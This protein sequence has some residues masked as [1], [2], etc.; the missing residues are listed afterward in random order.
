MQ[1]GGRWRGSGDDIALRDLGIGWLIPLW[2]AAAYLA[3]SAVSPL[4]T[5]GDLGIDAHAYWLT[6][7]HDDL[8]GPGPGNRDAYLYSPAF[9]TA[10][11]PLTQL[12]WPVFLGIWLACQAATFA[13]LLAPL[14]W[15]W[16]VPV[17]LL[18][19]P[20]MAQGNIYGLLAGCLVV[21]LRH[22][23]VWAFTLLTKITPGAVLVWFA[24]RREW[25]SLAAALFATAVIA[26]MSYALAPADWGEWVRFLIQNGEGSSSTLYLRI[27]VAVALTWIAARRD[28]TWLL[29]PALFLACP[30]MIGISNLAL[31]AAL[32][33]LAQMHHRRRA[34]SEGSHVGVPVGSITT[35]SGSIG[36][37]LNASA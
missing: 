13:W 28:T 4:V 27:A 1:R 11:W 29:A 21:G 3:W 36:G 20:V 31:F 14:H 7:Q 23:S 6:G 37:N 35:R 5:A 16:F 17:F 33:R 26:T 12:S 19:L 9:A 2:L 24:V 25:R 34:A 22:P 15:R 32:P 30:V 18:C 8:Y 10:I